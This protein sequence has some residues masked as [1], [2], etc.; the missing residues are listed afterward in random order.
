MDKAPLPPPRLK[1]LQ[2]K[3]T[4]ILIEAYLREQQRTYDAFVA[5]IPP[6][7]RQRTSARLAA[8]SEDVTVRLTSLTY[9]DRRAQWVEQR[10]RRRQ[11][12]IQ[13]FGFGVLVISIVGLCLALVYLLFLFYLGWQNLDLMRRGGRAAA[14][15]AAAKNSRNRPPLPP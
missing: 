11:H 6:G 4:E 13:M 8:S 5:Q 2:D 10:E 7:L 12:W 1:S 14:A 3:T 9:L 15:A